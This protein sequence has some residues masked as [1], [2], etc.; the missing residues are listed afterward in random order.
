MKFLAVVTPLSIYQYECASFINDD[1]EGISKGNP[2]E[3]EYQGP[4]DSPGID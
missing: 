1:E 2:N 4:Q 3:E